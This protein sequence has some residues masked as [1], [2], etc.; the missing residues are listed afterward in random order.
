MQR[1]RPIAFASMSDIIRTSRKGTLRDLIHM[2]ALP[3]IHRWETSN[4]AFWS[5]AS[6]F[7]R[8]KNPVGSPTAPVEDAFAAS[9]IQYSGGTQKW[10]RHTSKWLFV[11]H[12]ASWHIFKF[13]RWVRLTR[14]YCNTATLCYWQTSGSNQA[15]T[16]K[17]YSW[18]LVWN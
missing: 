10:E 12:V 8:Q 9:D 11:P 7:H 1:G 3:S 17:D 13:D 18:W 2:P 16:E 5:Q 6:L 14:T 4:S 15:S